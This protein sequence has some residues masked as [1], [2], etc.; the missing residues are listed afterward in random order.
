MAMKSRASLCSIILIS[1]LCLCSCKT[2]T[3]VEYRDR[4]VD[5]YITKE[6]HDTLRETTTDSVYV[7]VVTKGDTVYKTKYKEKVMWRDRVVERT[8][9]CWRDSIV[10]QIKETTKE[11]K[12]IPTFFWICFV[13]SSI[14]ITFA[15]V[16]L[17]IWLKT[18]FW[19]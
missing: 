4:V 7:E 16:K 17:A 3:R 13:F 9:T 1:I 12:H 14:I 11:V 19:V 10:T 15:L 2:I 18:R 5:H 6:V 8:D